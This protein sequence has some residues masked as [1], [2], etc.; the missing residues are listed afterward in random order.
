MRITQDLH[1]LVQEHA[2]HVQAGVVAPRLDKPVDVPVT[3]EA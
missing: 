1:K 2:A 3:A